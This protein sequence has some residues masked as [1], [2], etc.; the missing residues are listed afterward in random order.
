M[1]KVKVGIIGAGGI[2][3]VAHIP[4]FQKIT[5]VEVAAISDPNE[6]KLKFVAGKFKIGSSF[7]DY[8][9]ILEMDDISIVSICSPN[10]VHKEHAVESLKSGKHVLCEK[11]VAMSGAEAREILETAKTT[12]KKFMV[13]FP[14]RFAPGAVFLKKLVDRGE[15]GEIYYAKASCLRRRGIPGLGG[16]FT[17]K[18]MSGGG[19]L[20]DIGV[21]ILDKTYWLMGAPE[22]VSVTGVTYQKFK[23]KAFDGGWPPVETRVGDKYTQPLDVEDLSSAFIKFS[24]GA[25]LFLEASWAG[26]SEGGTSLSLFGT[27]KGAKDDGAS[28]K[29]YDEV[30]GVLLDNTP[31]LPGADTYFEEIKHFVS[32]VLEDKEPVTKPNEILNVIRIIESIYKSAESGKEIRL[33]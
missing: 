16:W 3:Q 2:A 9:K 5:G 15:F 21:H 20:I 11:P 23:D 6:E 8:R 31:V 1:A 24:N 26:N 33:E 29:I 4:N 22:L 14:S 12:K 25:S 10:F 7:T 32:C 28:L 17:T 19:P 27:K 30:N 13:A 18:K